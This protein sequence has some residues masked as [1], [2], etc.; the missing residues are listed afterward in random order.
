MNQ[1]LHTKKGKTM[2]KEDIYKTLLTKYCKQI[3]HMRQ[4]YALPSPTL[5]VV[6]GAG[7]SIDIGLPDWKNLVQRISQIGDIKNLHVETSRDDPIASAQLLYQAL[8]AHMIEK[9]SEDD[10]AYNRIDMKIRAKWQKIVHSALY[11]GVEQDVCKLVPENHYLWSLIK[12][13]KKI[14][15]TVNY[16]FDDTIQRMLSATRSKEELEHS[17]GYTTLWSANVFMYPKNSVIYHPNGFLP[18][19]IEEHPSERLVFLEDSFADQLIDSIHGHYNVLSDYFTHNTCLLIGLSLSDPTLKHILRTNAINYPGLYHYYIKYIEEGKTF[20]NEKTFTDANFDVYNLITLFL[21]KEEIAGLLELIDMDEDSF[22]KLVEEVGG[23]FKSYKYML[24]GSVAVGKSTAVSQFRNIATQDEWLD[25]MPREMAKD[26]S[27]VDEGRISD[28]DKWIA[29]QWE[30]KNYKLLRIT[31]GLHIID[32]GPLDAFAF[33][34]KGEWIQKAQLTKSHISRGQSGR[35]LCPAQII[36]LIG[37]PST[38]AS[39]AIL[40][41]KDTDAKKL[42]KQQKLIKYI[43][44]KAPQGISIIDTRNKG[45]AQVAKEIARIIFLSDYCEAPLEEMLN[46]ILNG[47]IPEPVDLLI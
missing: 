9:S 23:L 17:R 29:E 35:K 6:L 12:I 28:I 15:M 26:P 19:N 47:E 27:K 46:K 37:D 11:D 42:E 14:S 24:V 3:V 34:P 33:T 8:K 44:S 41:Q 30:K 25:F 13:V 5:G 20:E 4:Q 10:K 40:S 18:F 39:R 16:N 2:K 31:S 1:L 7:T 36:M 43:Y 45:K 22:N 32:R 38:M 21:T